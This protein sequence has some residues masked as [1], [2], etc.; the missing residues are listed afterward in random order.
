M[1][2]PASQHR[3]VDSRCEGRDTAPCPG[4]WQPAPEVQQ[5][6]VAASQERER[7]QTIQREF[8]DG[9]FGEDDN[10]SVFDISNPR[11]PRFLKRSGLSRAMNCLKITAPL[12]R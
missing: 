5:I 4:L 6:L 1:L 3:Q 9:N 2:R 10:L 12:T 8:W 7:M 11:Q